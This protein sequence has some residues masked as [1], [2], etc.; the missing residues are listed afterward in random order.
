MPRT[1]FGKTRP[2]DTPYA[3]Y[4]SRDGWV[5]KVLKTYK[6]SSAETT[7][8]HARWFVAATSPHMQTGHMRWATPIAA[9]LSLSA[10]WSMRIRNG[11]MNTLYNI[12]LGFCA[13]LA[14]SLVLFLPII[15]GWV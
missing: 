14:V 10:S 13:G 12:V 9:T 11:A 6:H 15:A 8:P 5:W 1:S 2:A 4:A 3:T 7:D